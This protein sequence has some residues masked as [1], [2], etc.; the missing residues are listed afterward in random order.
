MKIMNSQVLL[1]ILVFLTALSGCGTLT[2]QT[3]QLEQIHQ[4]YTTE[5]AQYSFQALPSPAPGPNMNTGNGSF[6]NTLAGIKNYKKTYGEGSKDVAAHLTVLEGMIYLQ[7]GKPGMAR[8]LSSEVEN[9]KKELKSPGGIATRDYIFAECYDDL[10]AGWEAIYQL[11]KE[12]C[13]KRPN[14]FKKPADDIAQKLSEILK[15]SRVTTDLDSGG[16][17]VATSTAIFYMW[18]H[19]C[20]PEDDEFSL[21]KMAKKGKDVLEPWLSPDEIRLVK[22]GS[23]NSSQYDWG[24]RRRYLD[25]YDFLLKESRDLRYSN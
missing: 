24:S 22:E 13:A 9:A 10:T 7:S 5:W 3:Y 23:Y 1:L 16:A 21:V 11:T 19:S 20:S 25:W 8:L 12:K 15:K 6:T 14:D 18:A 17:Y 2:S 4:Q